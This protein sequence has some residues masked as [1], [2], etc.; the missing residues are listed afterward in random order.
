[1]GI[2]EEMFIKKQFEEL[3]LK[4]LPL[5]HH[6]A[7][8]FANLPIEHD[9]LI[10]CGNIAFTK[11]MKLFD[12]SKS[13]WAT[14]FSTVM[15]N[16]ILMLNRKVSKNSVCISI[17]TVVHI[18]STGNTLALENLLADEHD[19]IAALHVKFAT[20]EV[21]MLIGELESRNK[22]IIEMYLSGVKQK[23]IGETLG[24][25]QSYVSR[26]IAKTIKQLRGAYAK[27]A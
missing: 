12:P 26:M 2:N 11:C 13:K 1:M 8:K 20:E 6:I 24:I 17:E 10:G 5:M 19:K 27:G 21:F 3:Y 7:K 15:T 25:S 22:L 23:Q 16:E 14:F 18:D 4:N 9:D